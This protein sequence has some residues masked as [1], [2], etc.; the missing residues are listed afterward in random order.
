M[1]SPSK[2][3]NTKSNK[4]VED[5]QIFPQLKLLNAC[6]NLS[7]FIKEKFFNISH[8]L[9]F[10]LKKQIPDLKDDLNINTDKI[11]KE[12]LN[13]KNFL[14]DLKQLF[15]SLNSI[16]NKIE[17]YSKKEADEEK[18]KILFDLN[19]QLNEYLKNI[20]KDKDKK[21]NYFI[22]PN[23]KISD[24]HIIDQ[25]N[26]FISLNNKNDDDS[27]ETIIIHKDNNFDNLSEIGEKE[28]E[29][30]SIFEEEKEIIENLKEEK[31]EKLNKKVEEF[32][33]N[34]YLIFLNHK[35]KR[36]ENNNELKK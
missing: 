18:I 4:I 2:I 25:I 12:M 6:Q 11:Y 9:N 1:S 32:K 8:S 16:I 29:K 15:T 31:K 21:H 26:K 36:N 19:K 20:P 7:K 23:T 10:N 3:I 17:L 14:N 13:D 33:L 5:N 22:S 27:K 35:K 34:D 30:E 28:S 24:N